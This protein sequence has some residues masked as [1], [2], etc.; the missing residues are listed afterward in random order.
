MLGD[1]K[2]LLGIEGDKRDDVLSLLI[3]NA[4]TQVLGQ[5]HVLKPTPTVVPEELSFIV[6]ELVIARF[7]R[8]GSEGLKQ[9]SVEGESSTYSDDFSAYDSVIA[10]YI[11][12][13]SNS[14]IGTVKFL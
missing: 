13:Q 4:E 9:H 12:S 8:I 6:L 2:L 7:N 1:V 5:L 11:E 14:K 10:Q 3:A